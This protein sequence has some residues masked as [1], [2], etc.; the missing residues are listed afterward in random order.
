MQ[1]IAPVQQS[2]PGSMAPRRM[3]NMQEP[4]NYNNIPTQ[5]YQP[6]SPSY[7]PRK[8][9]MQSARASINVRKPQVTD[10][11]NQQPPGFGDYL[12]LPVYQ[13]PQ[14]PVQTMNIDD[15]DIDMS[16]VSLDMPVL[17][18]K[19]P[20][21][22]EHFDIR[23][24][25]S[26][27]QK[28][29]ASARDMEWEPCL[30][31]TAPESVMSTDDVERELENLETLW[32][33]GFI[34]EEEYLRRKM[35]LRWAKEHSSNLYVPEAP[36]VVGRKPTRGKSRNVRLFISSTFRDMGT[37]REIIIKK[38]FPQ[39]QKF[40]KDRGVFLSCVDLRWGITS[41][42]TSSGSTLDICLSEIDRCRPY[43]I[44]MLANRYGWAKQGDKPDPMLDKTLEFA[45]KN[46]AWIE[47]YKDRSVTELEVRHAVL[48]D[49]N[50]N[51]AQHAL[52]YI[53]KQRGSSDDDLRLTKLKE[54]IKRSGLLNITD[55]SDHSAF[56][57]AVLTQLQERIERDFPK[58][59]VPSPLERQRMAHNAFKDTRARIYIGREKYFEVVNDHFAK[60][61][62]G[63]MLIVGES[64]SGKSAFVCNWT[65]RHQEKFPDRLV[66]PHYIG[67]TAEST[68]LSSMLRRVMGEIKEH[69]DLRMSIPTDLQKLIEALP[70][71][72]AEAGRR[73]GVTVVLDAL[74][75]LENKD[76]AH[77]L[78]WLPT[79]L[80]NNVLLLCS[81]LPGT[82]YNNVKS[83]NWR[84]MRIKPLDS[85]ERTQ[86]VTEYMAQY[87]KTLTEKQT[88]MIV[89]AAQCQNALFLRTLLE[90]V[91][92]FGVFEELEK[93]ISSLL[94]ARTPPQLFELV[95]K[96]L[97]RDYEKERKG[98]V[99]Q[100]MSLIWVARKGLTE[101]E[102]LSILNLPASI[103]APLF[104]A[105]DESLVSRGGYLTFFHDYMRQA[106][107]KRY[108]SSQSKKRSCRNTI[109][110]SFLDK[111]R[112]IDERRVLE[113]VP[114]QLERCELWDRLSAFVTDVK[115]FKS[116]CNDEYRF[117]MYRYWRGVG[118]HCPGAKPKFVKSIMNS[119]DEP[120]MLLAGKF[121]QDIGVYDVAETLLSAALAIARKRGDY[122]EELA[123]RIEGLA[124]LVRMRGRYKESIPLY[125]EAITLR[126][127]F[128]SDQDPKLASVYNSLAIVYRLSGKYDLA[129][130]LYER[131]LKLR[132]AIYG[133]MHEDIA[134][135]YNSLGCLNQDMGRYEKS[136]RFLFLAI[137]QRE[138]LLGNSHPDV[139][140]SVSNLGGLYLDWSKYDKAGE[141]YKR[142]LDIYVG[143]FGEEHPS[144][145]Q[146]LNSLAGLYQE[147]GDYDKA[148]G[149]YMRTLSVKKALLGELHPDYALT[150]NDVAVLYARQDKYPQA[151]K[152]YV[153]AVGI[154]KQVLGE[155]HPDY[156]QSLKNLASLY[157]DMGSY[158]KAEPLFKRG[159][160]IAEA[161]FGPNHLDVGS[162]CVTLAGLYQLTS[163]FNEAIPLYKRA[164][165]IYKTLGE[166]HA[167]IALTLNDFAILY[168]RKGDY[169]Q[170]TKFYLKALNN[171]EHVFGKDHPDV[172]MSNLNI[173][174]F[175]K[176]I[177]QPA[178][179]VS[180]AKEAIRIFIKRFGESHQKTQKAKGTLS[181]LQSSGPAAP[182]R[183]PTNRA[184]HRPKY[185]MN[186]AYGRH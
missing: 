122:N 34:P 180:H 149:V 51:T 117:D 50:S 153:Q 185:S 99:G 42:N 150:L 16:D 65:V 156:A 32:A 25:A 164:L 37:E 75:Q 114:Y 8:P 118:A 68:D 127:Q 72:L 70:N 1:N 129:E 97:E 86:L 111:S 155:Q 110:T 77:A 173:A 159:L 96:R 10:G 126:E 136:E 4:P 154:R 49:I 58:E 62:P 112:N 36:R 60:S 128:C 17:E 39:L 11:L 171:Y 83:R 186:R 178:K 104:M 181:D 89:N 43:F 105:L 24:T 46:F 161:A 26:K 169:T 183:G 124:Y 142:A 59:D 14:Q 125:K 93:H 5:V 57:E 81:T 144:V 130:P 120:A 53:R 74:N 19:R 158:A 138:T 182:S 102:V 108:L 90:E 40:C 22:P 67:S 100:L 76:N 131:A 116:L 85:V 52:F 163:R 147:Q 95:F 152:Y 78:R 54:E 133:E 123:G 175:Y 28:L 179:G 47:Q 41:E 63:P 177:G 13:Q 145:A 92:V 139:A 30:K 56:E 113:E 135:S 38:V 23:C 140:M 71:F 91:R 160:K 151:E 148:E 2:A 157:Q 132:K 141:N 146:S 167:D 33:E 94:R 174:Q 107:E 6:S 184:K 31:Y 20:S 73:G 106:V 166:F 109:V 27:K 45:K 98:L 61:K 82:C 69:W 35:V 168:Y 137:A 172:G 115:N 162:S 170:A 165:E 9:L 12:N 103:W 7:A 66:I 44:C 21:R 101:S 87:G 80:P 55:Y 84:E 143:V 119:K 48:N 176:A 64:G 29:R 79:Q 121:A 3:L 15:M 88:K 134:Q 18:F